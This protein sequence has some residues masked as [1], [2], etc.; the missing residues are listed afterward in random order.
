[1]PRDPIASLALALCIALFAL[2]GA[3]VML[4]VPFPTTYDELQHVSFIA[5]LRDAPTLFPHYGSYRILD[6]TLTRWT[7][8]QNY[9]AHPPLY[10]LLLAPFGNDVALL[11]AVN[12]LMALAGFALSAA[13]GV[14]L[15][16]TTMQ[17]VGF[18]T[19]LVVFSK[20]ALIAGMV[21]NDNLVLLETGLLLWVLTKATCH[22]RESGHPKS[23]LDSRFRGNDNQDRRDGLIV[24]ILLALIGWTKF[25]AFVG[26]TFFVGL[27]HIFNIFA[28]REKLLGRTSWLLL[29]G[30]FV[31]AIPT[32]VNLATFGAPA[33]VPTGFL[34]VDPPQRQAYDL[35]AFIAAFWHKIG[36]KI[37]YI[38]GIVD[39]LPFAVA[40][41]LLAA[42]AIFAP[43]SRQRD[44]AI[45][46]TTATLAFAAVHTFYG[47]NSFRALGS[48]SD[49]QSRYYVMLWPV[50]AMAAVV[51]A[52]ALSQ[53]R[54]SKARGVTS[55]RLRGE[56]AAPEAGGG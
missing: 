15:L 21:N 31:G 26:L 14:R 39:L 43:P 25:N 20:P 34:F 6:E 27:L 18:L 8:M 32:S 37:F 49:A 50:L 48:M 30:V 51:G 17:R 12:F 16:A 2:G 38:D 44:L 54:S 52:S 24:A 22:A 7:D 53:R 35:A 10:Y 33:W 47:W 3:F 42:C 9:L 46:A 23:S 4:R 40:M 29:T 36:L 56:V 1:M 11:R 19:L 41:V 5:A 45:S 55:P 13:A 28:R